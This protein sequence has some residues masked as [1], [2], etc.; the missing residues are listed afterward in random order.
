MDVAGYGHISILLIYSVLMEL[1]KSTGLFCTNY[2]G[3]NQKII[4]TKMTIT[5]LCWK[6]KLKENMEVQWK[7]W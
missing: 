7:M 2:T 3:L 6:R 4:S 1:I 5:N